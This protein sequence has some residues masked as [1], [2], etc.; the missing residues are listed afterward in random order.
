MRHAT[1]AFSGT[2]SDQQA[3]NFRGRVSRR[4]SHF[5]KAEVGRELN[6][7]KE[8]SPLDTLNQQNRSNESLVEEENESETFSGKTPKIIKV[9]NVKDNEID[10]ARLRLNKRLDFVT[11]TLRHKKAIK[12]F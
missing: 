8:T 6:D 11:L 2:E 9:T 10:F 3:A 4:K 5:D 12:N 1:S 7:L